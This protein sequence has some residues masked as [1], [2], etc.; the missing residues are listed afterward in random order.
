DEGGAGGLVVIDVV[1][2]QPAG[3]AVAQQQ[4]GLAGNAAEVSDAREL[5]IQA[6]GADEG[7]A[8]D[9]IVGDVVD[10]QSAG[11]GVAQ[12]QVAFVGAAATAVARE[13]PVQADRAHEGRAGDLVRL[14]LD[15]IVVPRPLP[16]R[17]KLR[18]L[19]WETTALQREPSVRG[20]RPCAKS[21]ISSAAR[22]SRA[23]PAAAV[24]CSTPIPARYKPRSASPTNRRWRRPSPMRR[25]R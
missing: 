3:I 19:T 10:F 11:V 6:D 21:A 24:T 2:F 8:G 18:Y 9:L 12:R 14:G 15:F 16:A 17:R 4:I 5:P 22:K 25:R 20:R 1:D 13:L 23:R 7:R